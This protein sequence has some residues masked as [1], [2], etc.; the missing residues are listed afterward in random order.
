LNWDFEG[1]VRLF[2]GHDMDDDGFDMATDFDHPPSTENNE[3]LASLSSLPS[4]SPFPPPPP[5][6]SFSNAHSLSDHENLMTEIR[7]PVYTTPDI[8]NHRFNY[9]NHS[10]EDDYYD[11]QSI[12]NTAANNEWGVRAPD[13]VRRSTLISGSSDMRAGTSH[14]DAPGVVWMFPPPSPLLTYTGPLQTVR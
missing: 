8:I 11:T 10:I 5:N 6:F 14:F 12:N 13:P 1:A 9:A 4:I 7:S 2:L 3:N